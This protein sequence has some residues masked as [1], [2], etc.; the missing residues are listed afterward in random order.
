MMAA[1]PVAAGVLY[2]SFRDA[3]SKGYNMSLP[4]KRSML[5]TYIKNGRGTARDIVESEKYAPTFGPFERHYLVSTHLLPTASLP[6][7]CSALM[8]LLELSAPTF[9]STH[10]RWHARGRSLVRRRRPFRR[11]CSRGN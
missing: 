2:G 8:S 6:P 9:L 3:K 10:G 4:N 7:P 1:R 11:H 5:E